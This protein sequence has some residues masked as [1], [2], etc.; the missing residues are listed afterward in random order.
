MVKQRAQTHEQQ[1]ES[2][3]S[4]YTKLF[5]AS[6]HPADR[7]GLSADEDNR[8]N[9]FHAENCTHANMWSPLTGQEKDPGRHRKEKKTD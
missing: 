1:V 9:S 4:K 8:W 5:V 6:L 7:S 3:P 2:G